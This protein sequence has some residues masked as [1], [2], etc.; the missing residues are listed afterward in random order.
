MTGDNKSIEETI[1][2]EKQPSDQRK[3]T[4][5]RTI[6]TRNQ[7]V[8][9]EHTSHI[10]RSMLTKQ[11]YGYT[12]QDVCSK[13]DAAYAALAYKDFIDRKCNIPYSIPL[14]HR[15]TWTPKELIMWQYSF[16]I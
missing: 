2:D 9:N 16:C 13:Y 4:T 1:R 12:L 7:K 3:S 11:L 14:L 8:S 6:R 10:S 5:D 15:G